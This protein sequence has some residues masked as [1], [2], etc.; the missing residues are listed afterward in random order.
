MK[1]TRVIA[2]NFVI[3]EGSI[4]SQT[5]KVEIGSLHIGLYCPAL[6]ELISKANEVG[7]YQ[8]LENINPEG[9]EVFAFLYE[10]FR[11]KI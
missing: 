9:R 1:G 10:E 4:D 6:R 8:V 7:V 3:V 5:M 11:D 2:C